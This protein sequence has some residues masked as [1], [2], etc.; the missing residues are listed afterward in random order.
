MDKFIWTERVRN[1]EILHRVIEERNIIHA[2]KG[3]KAN[4]IG[5]IWRG[6]CL[7]KHINEGKIEESIEV[8]GGRGRKY[9]QLLDDLK[10]KSW[11]LKLKEEA[12]DRTVW[13]NGL[14]RGCGPVVGQT[15]KW[16]NITRLTSSAC[17]QS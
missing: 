7:L 3:R 15:V 16:M 12:L 14:G 17:S 9:K 5:H 13:R 1:E 4:W 10:E 6:N 11:C 8:K 2:S